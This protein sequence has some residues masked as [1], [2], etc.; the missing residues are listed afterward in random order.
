MEFAPLGEV[1]SRQRALTEGV[2]LGGAF[3]VHDTPPAVGADLVLW[4]HPDAPAPGQPG[5]LRLRAQ[6]RWIDAMPEQ[7]PRGFGV[8]FRALTAADEVV[9]HG[10][11]SRSSKK[12]V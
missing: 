4:L 3:V 11:F 9:L 6:V 8:A 10:W 7:R 12:V 5:V 1:A 2:S